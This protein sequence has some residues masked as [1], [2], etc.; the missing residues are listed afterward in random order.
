MLHLYITIQLEDFAEKP[1]EPLSSS[2]D[3]TSLMGKAQWQSYW[4]G[5]F[6]VSSNIFASVSAIDIAN[7]NSYFRMAKQVE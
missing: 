6:S 5:G 7:R 3:P 2:A 1:K 4:N